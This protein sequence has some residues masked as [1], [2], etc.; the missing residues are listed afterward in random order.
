MIKCHYYLCERH[1]KNGAYCL[2]AVCTM[3]DETLSKFIAEKE[4]DRL[5]I[6]KQ[7]TALN[8]TTEE[9]YEITELTEKER[10]EV[11]RWRKT[12]ISNYWGQ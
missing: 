12:C 6:Y 1:C 4:E 3:S 11:E 5:N 7:N 8:L 2:Y 9:H 10:V